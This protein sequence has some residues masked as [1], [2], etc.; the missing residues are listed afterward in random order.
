MEIENE[1]PNSRFGY[2]Y[3][4]EVEQFEQEV[5][6]E[7]EQEG[8]EVIPEQESE[9][10]VII[11]PEI[12]ITSQVKQIGFFKQP[13]GKVTIIVVALAALYGAYSIMTKKGA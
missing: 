5:E 11:E 4:Q 7:V 9:T 2:T 12:K 6:Q 13:I 3:E 10:A 1:L 8:N